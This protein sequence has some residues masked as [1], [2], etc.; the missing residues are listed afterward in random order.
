MIAPKG[1]RGRGGGGW[2]PT[3]SKDAMSIGGGGGYPLSHVKNFFGN[4]VIKNKD[5]GAL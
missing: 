1:G 3:I 5:Y 4:L 2:K